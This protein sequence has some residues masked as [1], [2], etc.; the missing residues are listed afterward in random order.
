M[1]L[2]FHGR[3]RSLLMGADHHVVLPDGRRLA[4]AD[5]GD[6]AARAVLYFHGG[7]SC[8]LDIGFGAED[9]KTDG[10][11]LIAPD[12][13]GIGGSDRSRGRSVASWAADVSALADGLSLGRF[14]VLGWSAG[15]PYALACAAL[16]PDRVTSVA[17]VGGAPPLQG[18]ADVKELGLRGDRMLFPLAHHVPA[19]AAPV[20][21]ITGRMPVRLLRKQLLADIRSTA[22]RAAVAEFDWRAV[23]EAVRHGGAGTVDDYRALAADWG[24]DPATITAPV[25]LW[26]GGDDDLVPIAHARRLAY[27]I[28]AA[29][30]EVVRGAGHFLLHGHLA[31]VLDSLTAADVR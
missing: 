26:H 6:P 10:T 4:Y 27:L 1:P 8:R 9:A 23:R 14:A 3:L 20:L 28:P 29:R 13:P 7:L 30:Y 19:L 5:W 11:R 18:R 12:R 21:A 22:D 16:L 2:P 24:F 25:T 15:A 17:T 31:A